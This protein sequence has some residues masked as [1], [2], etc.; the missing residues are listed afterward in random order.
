MTSSCDEMRTTIQWQEVL[1]IKSLG[2]NKKHHCIL[3]DDA[4]IQ[5][6]LLS[7]SVKVLHK[8]TLNNF[9][10]SNSNFFLKTSLLVLKKQIVVI[11]LCSRK[12]SLHDVQCKSCYTDKLYQS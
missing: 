7:T 12:F 10:F 9:V 11:S 5:F 2:F 6:P 8:L 4:Y 1:R 3:P